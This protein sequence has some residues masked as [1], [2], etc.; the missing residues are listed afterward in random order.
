[1]WTEQTA[2]R[3]TYLLAPLASSTNDA[4][5]LI[6]ASRHY[7]GLL[8]VVLVIISSNHAPSALVPSV[9]ETR[10]TISRHLDVLRQPADAFTVAL[11]HN[12]RAHEDLNGPYAFEGYFAFAG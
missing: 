12:D 4:A 3:S 6:N 10:S 1:M 11:A 8:Q 9:P 2:M 5:H 7:I